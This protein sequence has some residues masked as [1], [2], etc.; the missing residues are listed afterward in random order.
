MATTNN[1]N[2]SNSYTAARLSMVRNQIQQRGISDSGVLQAMRDVP[3]HRFVDPEWRDQAYDDRPLQ[4]GA[5]QTISQP[6]MV[7][8]MLQELALPPEARVLEVGTG[9]GYQAAIL[10]RIASQV[11]SIEYFPTLAN[12][13]RQVLS[14]LDYTNVEIVIG[15]GGTGLPQHAPFHGIVVAAGAPQIPSPLLAQLTQAG[16]LVVPIGDVDKQEL[17]ILTKQGRS[18]TRK[19]GVSCRF[20]PLLG[21]EGW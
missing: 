16:R 20:V 7:A 5:G 4:I 19:R 17:C 3:R 6:Y 12:K 11:Y 8:L 10:S 21:K 1:M 9:S 14:E 18:F 15:D 2:G 13:A